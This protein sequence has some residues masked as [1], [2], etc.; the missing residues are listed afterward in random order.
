MYYRKILAINM[1]FGNFWTGY[2][3]C[4][5]TRL[6]LPNNT[7]SNNVNHAPMLSP[8]CNEANTTYN[9]LQC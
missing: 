7:M 8:S 2:E 9:Y 3:C 5:T 6:F 4:V 1:A